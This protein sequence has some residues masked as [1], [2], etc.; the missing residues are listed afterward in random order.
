MDIR[1]FENLITRASK[2]VEEAR[3]D[4][5]R[6]IRRK[7]V[8]SKLK[9]VQGQLASVEKI[10]DDLAKLNR[11]PSDYVNA[12]M[13]QLKKEEQVLLVEMEELGEVPFYPEPKKTDVQYSEFFLESPFKEEIT[14]LIQEGRTAKL[15]EMSSDIRRLTFDQWALRWRIVGEK[16]GQDKVTRSREMQTCYAVIK[17]AMNEN[18]ADCHHIPALKR[19]I[20]EN[21][22]EQLRQTK[23]KIKATQDREMRFQLA[24]EQ[25]G[26]LKKL[27]LDAKTDADGL[28]R[29]KHLVRT[30]AVNSALRDDLA[31]I[32]A[33]YKSLLEDEFAFL[34]KGDASE[35]AEVVK[36]KLTNRDVLAR[37]LR[38]MISKTLIGGCHGPLDRVCTGFPEHDKHRARHIMNLMIRV[39]A[40]R[41]K[42]NEGADIRVSIEPTYVGQC[43]NFVK[44]QEFGQKAIDV[45]VQSDTAVEAAK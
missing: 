32:C 8:E 6:G 26:S 43:E 36:E 37:L 29:Y 27:T 16:I 9:L 21:W 18:P 1:E 28:R 17:T 34:W 39:G 30:I 4:T 15:H 12:A 7:A 40:I 11:E 3:E 19:E 24:L 14:M 41:A 35:E 20:Q 10:I 2:E 5:E 23:A 38:R 45:W 44:G 42:K 22:E 25:L 33:P 13:M 31:E